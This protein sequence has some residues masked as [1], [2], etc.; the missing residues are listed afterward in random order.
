VAR[1]VVSRRWV[2]RALV[3]VIARVLFAD[4]GYADA[5]KTTEEVVKTIEVALGSVWAGQ[6]LASV[7]ARR[8]LIIGAYVL[9]VAVRVALA[10][11]RLAA[12]NQRN[13]AQRAD[14]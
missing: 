1:T 11:S 13:Y 12:P 8:A 2:V 6:I 3:A 9:V 10:L 4:A 5:V 7:G 14:T